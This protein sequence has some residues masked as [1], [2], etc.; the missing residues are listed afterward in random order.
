MRFA[1][2]VLK[3]SGDPDS[4]QGTLLREERVRVEHFEE[5]ARNATAVVLNYLP[6]SFS[7]STSVSFPLL[8]LCFGGMSFP[9]NPKNR[10]CKSISDIWCA[11]RLIGPRQFN[12]VGPVDSVVFSRVGQKRILGLCGSAWHGGPRL[13]RK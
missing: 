12:R 6:P 8:S 1:E 7:L 5:F 4:A 10:L 11:R 3:M 2:L 9:R 13:R